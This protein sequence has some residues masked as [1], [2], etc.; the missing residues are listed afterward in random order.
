MSFLIPPG[1]V[2]FQGNHRQLLLL[3]VHRRLASSTRAL[4]RS[5]ARVAAR[6]RRLVSA[7]D[8]EVLEDVRELYDDERVKDGWGSRFD[9]E[10]L[11][12]GAQLISRGADV[13]EGGEGENQDIV[14]EVVPAAN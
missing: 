13:R 10:Q 5:L 1:I 2:A 11:G 14:R 8:T 12:S 6:L 3:G 9:Y 7:P 4:A